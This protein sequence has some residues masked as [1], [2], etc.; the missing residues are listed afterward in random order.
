MTAAR[1]LPANGRCATR[2]DR[3]RQ[4]HLVRHPGCPARPGRP[5][6]RRYLRRPQG[7]L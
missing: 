2:S 3:R 1:A 6:R 5:G 4:N 7:L